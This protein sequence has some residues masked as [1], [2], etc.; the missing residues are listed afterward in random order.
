L[1]NLATAD[2]DS[3]APRCDG[4]RAQTQKKRGVGGFGGFSPFAAAA[5]TEI[6]RDG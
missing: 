1:G 4:G 3:D 2:A 5:R 6:S